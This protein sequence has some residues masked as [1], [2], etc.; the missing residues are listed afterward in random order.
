MKAL[1]NGIA[2]QTSLTVFEMVSKTL[3]LPKTLA[4]KDTLKAF[5]DF[6]NKQHKC[7]K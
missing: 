5:D 6:K 2:F 1:S 7:M 4:F 3:V